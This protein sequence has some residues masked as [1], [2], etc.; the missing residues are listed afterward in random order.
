VVVVAVREAEIEEMDFIPQPSIATVDASVSA[1]PRDQPP[2]QKTE[3]RWGG[4]GL[5]D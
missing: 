4:L 1:P 5:E 3:R 2:F